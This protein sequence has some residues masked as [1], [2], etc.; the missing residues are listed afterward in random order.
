MILTTIGWKKLNVDGIIVDDYSLSN[1]ESNIENLDKNSKTYQ[2]FKWILEFPGTRS[3][4]PF[5]KDYSQNYLK[6]L[7]TQN[8]LSLLRESLR[9]QKNDPLTQARTIF[10]NEAV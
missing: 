4:S 7:T 8:N 6:N 3:D 1:I 9:I 5:R 2:F 10:L